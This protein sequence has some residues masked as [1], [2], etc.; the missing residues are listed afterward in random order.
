MRTGGQDPEDATA[1][2]ARWL[3]DLNGY[4][5]EPATLQLLQSCDGKNSSSSCGIL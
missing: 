4:V 5:S 3:N 1:R 2:V